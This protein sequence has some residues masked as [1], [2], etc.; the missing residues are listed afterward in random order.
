[1]LIF[2]ILLLDMNPLKREKNTVTLMLGFLS[3]FKIIV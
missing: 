1:M 3:R 2:P